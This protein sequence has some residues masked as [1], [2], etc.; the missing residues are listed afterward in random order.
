MFGEPTAQEASPMRVWNAT[1]KRWKKLKRWASLPSSQLAPA[2]RPLF[3]CATCGHVN[4]YGELCLQCAR[5]G[6]VPLATSTLKRRRVSA[7]QPLNDSQKQQMRR[8][9]QRMATLYKPVQ[10]P[11]ASHDVDEFTAYPPETRTVRRRR[12]RAA[13]VLSVRDVEA[14]AYLSPEAKFYVQSIIVGRDDNVAS[15]PSPVSSKHADIAADEREA[16]VTPV[17]ASTPSPPRTLRRK[18]R[19][20]LSRQRSG[21]LRSRPGLRLSTLSTGDHVPPTPVNSPARPQFVSAMSTPLPSLDRVFG[22][23]PLGHPA[24]PFY[25]AIRRLSPTPQSAAVD[26]TL[27]V[28]TSS[29]VS[30]GMTIAH[31]RARS[32][33]LQPSVEIGEAESHILRCFS[34]PYAVDLSSG[35]T[36][37][38]ITGEM[39]LRMA[40]ARRNT[41][42][43]SAAHPEYRF[44]YPVCEVQ[45]RSFG[46]KM[47]VK[48]IGQGLRN[49]VLLRRP[50]TPSAS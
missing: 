13:A 47:R 22:A 38:S 14:V 29:A 9:Q 35:A 33:D 3:S 4:T 45:K 11:E 48:K 50:S 30:D 42:G 43:G 8:I 2:N 39:E 24:R 28:R 31:P 6:C 34:R 19:F 44:E 12:H 17:F 41:I 26:S 23:V 36:G 5:P 10:D 27:R 25:T 15:P 49:L 16:V 1:E 21:S 18:K 40:L 32:L 20:S 7:P 46:V 37:C